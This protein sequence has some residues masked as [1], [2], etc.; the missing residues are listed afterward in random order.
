MIVHPL[1]CPN[2][3]EPF[4]NGKP[5][6]KCGWVK[7]ELSPHAIRHIEET[8]GP[9]SEPNRSLLSRRN[10][11]ELIER[12]V[13]EHKSGNSALLEEM[14]SQLERADAAKEVLREKGYGRTGMDLL[15]IAR[16]IPHSPL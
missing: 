10:Y 8:W 14:S 2:C 5:C 7:R 3:G 6:A 13:R 16:E 15:M 1:S 4:T 9:S 12:A 11:Q